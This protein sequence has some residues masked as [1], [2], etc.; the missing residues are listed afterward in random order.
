MPNEV[1]WGINLTLGGAPGGGSPPSYGPPPGASKT[2]VRFKGIIV[3][4][5]LS[6]KLIPS[7]DVTWDAKGERI[8]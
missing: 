3:E 5:K 8:S 2:E 1:E 4:N 7:E 6:G